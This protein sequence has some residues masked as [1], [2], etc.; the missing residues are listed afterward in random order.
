MRILIIAMADS[1]HTV[2]WISQIADQGWEVHLFPSIDHG[3]MHPDLSDLHV[4]LPIYGERKCSRSV[5]ISGFPVYNDSLAR[6]LSLFLTKAPF[7]R[8]YQI[9]RLLRTIKKVK[10]DII[11]SLEMQH[12]G[13]LTLEARKRAVGRFPPWIVTNW[14]SDI[15]L[16]GNLPE[17]EPKIR[18]VLA[19]CDYYSCECQRDVLLARNFGFKGTVLPV[20]PNSGGFDM[21][22]I[23]AL[24]APGPVASRRTIM[25]KGYQSWSG[26]ALVGLRA[27]ERCAGL[28]QDYEVVIYSATEE[29][30]IA[31]ALFQRHTGVRTTIVPRYTPHQEILRKHGQA[32]ISLGLSIS[33]GVSTSFLEALAMGSFPIQTWTA[34]ADEWIEDGR[35][36]IL[37]PPDDPEIVEQALRRALTDDELINT[38]A[39]RNYQTAMKRLDRSALRPVAAEYYTSIVKG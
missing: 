26:R 11:H 12:A 34:C 37:V 3:M 7:Y 15:Y 27:L 1:I 23:A 2:R 10:P 16:F 38:A 35:T 31:A 19:A 29:V 18:E 17:H 25:L 9:N 30:L 8:N 21:D 4:T 28:L 5:K 24:R 39:E 6:G 14:G 32:R 22:R 33:D 20:H 13:Y 36:G